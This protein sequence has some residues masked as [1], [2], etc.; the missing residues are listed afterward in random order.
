LRALA[1]TTETRW[2]G[3]PDLPTVSDAVLGYEASA[4][5]GTR[6]PKSTPSEIIDELNREMDAALADA[7]N[8]AQLAELAATA[9]PGSPGAFGKLMAE[10]TEKWGKVVKFSGAK[11]D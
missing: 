5:F 4:V 2:E 11:A 3:L 7:K 8:K 6:A 1:V 10:E 9:L